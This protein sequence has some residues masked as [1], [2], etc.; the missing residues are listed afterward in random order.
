MF[1]RFISDLHLEFQ[2]DRMPPFTI[3]ELDTDAD[4]VLVLAGDVAVAKRPA[5]YKDLINDALGRFKHVIWIMGNHEHYSGSVQTSIPRILKNLG[6]SKAMHEHGN[7]SVIENEVVSIENTDFICATLW[8]DMANGNPVGMWKVQSM[9]NDF[10][11]IRTG[12]ATKPG[13]VD[14]PYKRP[15]RPEDTVIWNRESVDFITRST[16][17]ASLTNRKVVVVTHHAPSYR[18][19]GSEFRGS[20]MNIAYASPLDMLIETLEP[21]YWIHGHMH[22]TN[23]YNIGKTNILSNPRG[24]VPSELNPEF[25]PTWTIDLS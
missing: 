9:M 25:D 7:L 1:M 14:N 12:D 22:N 6:V 21:D 8:T 11:R 17:K 13:F 4:T 5:Q 2:T 16:G 18:S 10:K 19:V 3:P 24:Y 23:D 20:D 15:L